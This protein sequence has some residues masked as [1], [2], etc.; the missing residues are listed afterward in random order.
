MPGLI[1]E[2]GPIGI[3]GQKGGTGIPGNV[4]RI[5]SESQKLKM[6]NVHFFSFTSNTY[7]TNLY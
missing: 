2:T 3:P 7:F 6:C 4:G 1:G 5:V